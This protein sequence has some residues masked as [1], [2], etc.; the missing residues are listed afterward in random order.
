MNM[1]RFV[2]SG[3]KMKTTYLKLV[4]VFLISSIFLSGCWMFT[5]SENTDKNTTDDE[6]LT[7]L[8]PPPSDP[9]F[10][11]EW[12]TGNSNTIQLPLISNGIY[13]FTVYWD[14]GDSDIITSYNDPA[15]THTYSS[16]GRYKIIIEGELLGFSFSYGVGD[17][18]KIVKISNWGTLKLGNDGYYFY[19]CENLT[20]TAT[21]ILDCS[22]ITDMRYA[23]AYCSSLTTVPS[24]ND[25]DVSKATTMHFM[26]FNASKFDQYIGNWNVSSVQD[27]GSMFC[28]AGEFNQA[29]GEWTLSSVFEMRY[30]FSDASKF[31]QDIDKWNVSDSVP[32]DHMF[33]GCPISP[34]PSWY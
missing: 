14:D 1:D 13:N 7:T 16:Q 5:V 24:M 26:F 15:V 18:L 32:K 12:D 11:S 30:M 20:I 4:L 25:W 17:C 8:P 29:I 31:D 10:I 6:E 9:R 2:L 27:M 3:V 22:G 28:G 23:F 34:L 19:G 21:D 33:D